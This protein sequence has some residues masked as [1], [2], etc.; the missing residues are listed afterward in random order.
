MAASAV[1]SPSIQTSWERLQSAVHGGRAAGVAENA[2]GKLA[3][4]IDMAPARLR[5]SWPRQA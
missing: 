3:A 5:D 4:E 2:C 1:Q